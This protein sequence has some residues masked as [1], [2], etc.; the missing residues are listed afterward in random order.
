ME[1]IVVGLPHAQHQS[2]NDTW[3]S[4]IRTRVPDGYQLAFCERDL[5]FVSVARNEI[6]KEALKKGFDYL[7]FV[8]DD[9]RFDPDVLPKLIEDDRDVVGAL[10]FSRREPHL[11]S[12]WKSNSKE[13]RLYDSMIVYPQDSLVECDAIGMACTL[14]KRDVFDKIEP[15]QYK[16]LDLYFQYQEDPR[17]GEDM[18]FCKLAK[19]AGFSIYCDTSVE[20]E[21]ATV[22]WIS[23]SDYEMYAEW[24]IMQAVKKSKPKEYNKLFKS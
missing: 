13:Q 2:Y 15:E 6:V 8:D 18:F 5:K 17:I 24:N 19:K 10:T 7:W 4:I 22:K 23:E 1:K 3:R 9:M 21:H 11:P 12:I 16:N 14:I 20:A